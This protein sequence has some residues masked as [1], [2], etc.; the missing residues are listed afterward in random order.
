MSF[1]RIPIAAAVAL[2]FGVLCPSTSFAQQAASGTAAVD[3][4]GKLRAPTA[5]ERRQLHEARQAEQKQ[6]VDP[7]PVIRK[8]GSVHVQVP[9]H[10]ESVSVARVENGNVVTRCF[11]DRAQAEAFLAGQPSAPAAEEK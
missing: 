5:E 3:E 9:E 8:D 1:I 10:L 6:A 4:D 2:A 7:E 11:D